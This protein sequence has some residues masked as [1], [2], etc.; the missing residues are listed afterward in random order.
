MTGAMLS[1]DQH[2]QG[3]ALHPL[4]P[5]KRGRL[6][7]MQDARAP[8]KMIVHEEL[9]PLA[10]PADVWQAVRPT[11]IGVPAHGERTV[12]TF[13]LLSECDWNPEHGLVVRFRNG[14]AATSQ[15]GELGI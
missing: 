11:L 2:P 14:R 4:Q 10:S 9:P 13:P 1:I 12:P 7:R 6:A 15:Q 5:W 8:K 3:L